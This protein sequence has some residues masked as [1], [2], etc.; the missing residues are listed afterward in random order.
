MSDLLDTIKV[1]NQC[2]NL[3]IPC[4]LCY[5]S[6]IPSAVT[7]LEQT[8]AMLKYSKKPIYG[9]GLSSATNAKY[10]AELFKLYCNGDLQENPIGMVGISPE[11]PL[12][13]P[14]EITDTMRH[15]IGA[16][17]QSTSL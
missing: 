1:M 13:L 5:P 16:G 17:I 11:S 6:D 8:A 10:I 2:D 3:T 4:A 7:Q 9:P 14:K 15:I 12:F